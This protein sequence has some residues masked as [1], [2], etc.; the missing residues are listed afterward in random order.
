MQ[1]EDYARGTR[2]VDFTGTKPDS[3]NVV[4]ITSTR[5][6]DALE[7]LRAVRRARKQDEAARN[8]MAIGLL[9]ALVAFMFVILV[10]WV[11]FR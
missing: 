3:K 11:A 4:S 10:L 6:V 1:H 9:A 8:R 2:L 5:Q 7:Q